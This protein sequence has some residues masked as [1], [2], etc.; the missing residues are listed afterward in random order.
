MVN[1]KFKGLNPFQDFET[2]DFVCDKKKKCCKKWK[3][4]DACKKCPKH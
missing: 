4:G 3:K 2:H 1:D